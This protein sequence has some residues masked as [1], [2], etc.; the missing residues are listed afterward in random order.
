M[1][2]INAVVGDL[3]RDNQMVLRIDRYL[4]VVADDACPPRLHRACVRVRERHLLVRRC[5][6]LNFDLLEDLHLLLE[7]RNLV[8]QPFCLCFR[9]RRLL[10]IGGVHLHKITAD[11]CLDVPHSPF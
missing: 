1:V 5:V 3:V 6:E 11:A 9:D 4:N 10:A 7:S 2:T 8:L